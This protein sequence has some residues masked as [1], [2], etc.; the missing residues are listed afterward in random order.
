MLTTTSLLGVA[1]FATTVLSHG[2][3]VT[4]PVRADGPAMKAACVS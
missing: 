2:Q 3:I 4:P 1:L